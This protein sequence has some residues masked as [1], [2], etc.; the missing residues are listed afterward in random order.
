MLFEVSG[1]STLTAI[2]FIGFCDVFVTYRIISM[3]LLKLHSARRKQ[4]ILEGKDR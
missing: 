4:K 3:R 1:G 2:Y